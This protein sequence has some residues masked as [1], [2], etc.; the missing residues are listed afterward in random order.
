MAENRNIANFYK[1]IQNQSGL[2]LSYQF[3]VR[4]AFPEGILRD[5]GVNTSYDNV[6]W[7]QLGITDP[8]TLNELTNPNPQDPTRN[9]IFF[10]QGTSVPQ[11]RINT[12]QVEYF[13]QSFRFPSIIT[14]DENWSLSIL[15][16]EKLT[17]YRQLVAWQ[18]LISSI[19]RNNGGNKTIPNVYGDVQ[20]LNSFGNAIQRRFTIEGIFPNSVPRLSMRYQ[21]GGGSPMMLDPVQFTMQ[22]FRQVPVDQVPTD[23]FKE[24]V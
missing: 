3:L 18:E 16:D 6:I 4:L 14:Y 9:L 23:P 8:Y 22:Y 1:E 21:D 10:A 7:R 20:L 17:I 11:T 5:R 24:L 12:V 13:A 15:L 19:A 2:R